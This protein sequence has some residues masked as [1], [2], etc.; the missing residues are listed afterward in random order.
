MGAAVTEA[1]Q[2]QGV[3]DIAEAVLALFA[4]GWVT[5]QTLVVDGGLTLVSSTDLP[6]I[7]PQVLYQ[8]H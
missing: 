2:R 6:G 3:E 8:R 1:L 7:T 5:G 4:L